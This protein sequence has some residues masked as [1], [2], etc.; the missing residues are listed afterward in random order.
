MNADDDLDTGYLSYMLRIWRKR[1]GQGQLVW[2]ASLEEPGSHQ[3]A[4]FGDLRD[5]CAFLQSRV[6]LAP[7]GEPARQEP[8]EESRGRDG[9]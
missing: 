6:G 9:D 8:R 4:S 7:Q 1:D 3:M 2:C 5:M